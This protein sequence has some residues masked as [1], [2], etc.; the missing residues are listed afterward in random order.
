SDASRA[1]RWLLRVRGPVDVEITDEKG[2]RIG[3]YIE[4]EEEEEERRLGRR[5][6]RGEGEEGS[7]ELPN[8]YEV[9][10]PGASYNPGQNFTSA[11]LT[12]PGVYTCN[13]LG[14]TP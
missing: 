11:F 8:I 10:I 7:Q 3:R 2:F 4:R 9:S 1:D 6:E 5:R 13:F 14:Q 12:Q